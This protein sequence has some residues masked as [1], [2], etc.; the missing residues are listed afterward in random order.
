MGNGQS[1][2]L[3]TCLSN[4]CNGRSGCVGFPSDPLYQITWVKPYNL[5][6]Q[7]A[8]KP[9]AVVKPSTAQDVS[10]FVKCA[11]QNGAQVQAKSG[12]HSYA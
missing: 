9:I 4:V 6:S 3:E 2:P 10:G 1:T 5:D 8:V 7:A 11:A 12:G